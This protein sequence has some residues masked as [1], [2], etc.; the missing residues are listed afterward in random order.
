M[1]T[2]LRRALLIVMA[3]AIA[4]AI[5]LAARLAFFGGS[6]PGD[7][8]ALIGGPFTLQ[9]QNGRPVSDTDFRG[10]LLLVYFGYTFCP[11]VC[12]TEL[13]TISLALDQLGKDAA[14]VQPLFITVDPARDTPAVLKDYMSNFYPGFL[15]LTGTPD[16]VATAAKGYR[17]YYAKAPVPAGG[18]ADYLMDHSGFV[19]LMDREGHYLAH[20]VPN[21]PP[22]KIAERIRKA[23]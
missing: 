4:L 8:L 5:G 1:Q 18:A 3:A 7:G 12:P 9:D 6:L 14:K 16:Q 22:E 20:F 2:G 15:G 21:T 13:Q 11:D 19:Y 10:K 17:V 23:L